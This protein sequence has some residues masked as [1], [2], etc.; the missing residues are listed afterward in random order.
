MVN[1][2]EDM[3]TSDFAITVMPAP[4]LDG[5]M[6]VFGEVVSGIEVRKLCLAAC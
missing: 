5:T 4:N 1:D 2:G 3:N 6:V